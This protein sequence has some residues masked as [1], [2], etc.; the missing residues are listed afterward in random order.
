MI[1]V[2]F[3]QVIIS[4]LMVAVHTY[5]KN[6]EIN[7]DMLRHMILNSL[8]SYRRKFGEEYGELVLCCDARNYWRKD[9]FRYYKAGR[10][11]TR[12]ES[13]LDWT[14]IFETL[15]KIRDEIEEFFPY[16]V[17]T[18]DR[19]EADD[20]IAVLV[21]NK[22]PFEKVLILSGDKDF[23][24]LQ[25]NIGVDQYAPVQKK[26]LRSNDPAKYLKEHILRGDSSDGIPNFLSPDDVFVR[27]G[28]KQSPIYATKMKKWLDC[29]SPVDFCT[30]EQ[31]RNH[32]RNTILIDL[33]YIPVEIKTA[34]QTTFENAKPGNRMKLLTYFIEHKLKNLMGCIQD[35]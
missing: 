8:R 19:C 30:D 7:E 24:Q 29:A 9:V 10:K 34:I 23:M 16:I 13:T 12:K 3:S 14:N 18:V 5:N 17:L 21:Q 25:V 32:N 26:F 2:D 1:L 4:N 31:L 33:D 27:G 20:I 11:K 22:N 15:N 35:F 28:K 6:N